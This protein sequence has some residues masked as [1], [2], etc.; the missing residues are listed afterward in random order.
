MNN[1]KMVTMD[2]E[3]QV[4]EDS[5]NKLGHISRKSVRIL[6]CCVL[7]GLALI[8][9]VRQFFVVSKNGVDIGLPST[10]VLFAMSLVGMSF[11]GMGERKYW[12]VS[13]KRWGTYS[14]IMLS[15]AVLSMMITY[16]LLAP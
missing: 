3:N 4:P 8:L 14:L 6:M 12:G 11:S 1:D 7:I 2:N 13:D 10:L 16:F 5:K 9:E 15:I